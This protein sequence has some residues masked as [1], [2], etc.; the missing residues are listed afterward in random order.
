MTLTKNRMLSPE[1][2]EEFTAS[3]SSS[4]PVSSLA[5][6]PSSVSHL[7]YPANERGTQLQPCQE[8]RWAHAGTHTNPWLSIRAE[9][10]KPSRPHSLARA[11]AASS[12][13]SCH[14]EETKGSHMG[15]QSRQQGQRPTQLP[16]SPATCLWPAFGCRRVG[17][18][19]PSCSATNGLT[20]PTEP[21]WHQLNL[22]AAQH[23]SL[24]GGWGVVRF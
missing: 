6:Q 15:P 23:Q 16:C 8:L 11:F 22:P 14:R 10:A 7:R 21:P 4:P 24:E 12:W 2:M 20:A 13:G 3:K 1:T 19:A 9:G 5:S 18:L 17:G